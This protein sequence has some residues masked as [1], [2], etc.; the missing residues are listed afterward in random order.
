MGGLKGSNNTGKYI[1]TLAL[2]LSSV[3]VICGYSFAK[4]VEYSVTERPDGGYTLNIN[5]SKRH[6]I[7]I[8]GEGFFPL[9]K[10]NYTIDII[11]KGKD[12][13]SRQEKGYYYTPEDVK[14]V[15]KLW[16]F[17]YAWIDTERTYLYLNMYWVSLPDGIVPSKLNG[18]Y[19]LKR[20]IA[21]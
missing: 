18:K 10:G 7:P 4:D 17:G 5:Y 15:G 16:D 3:F 1:L 21:E 11:G 13:T 8:T 2:A 20:K 9:E 19:R 14:S 6:W 12:Y